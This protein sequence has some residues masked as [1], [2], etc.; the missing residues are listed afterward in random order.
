MVTIENRNDVNSIT[1]FK[2]FFIY[3]SFIQVFLCDN[4]VALGRY[5]GKNILN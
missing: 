3:W 2:W 5:L 4:Y 1:L